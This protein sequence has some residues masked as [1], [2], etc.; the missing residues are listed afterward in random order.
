[1]EQSLLDKH[2]GFSTIHQVVEG[3]YDG[4]LEN[5]ILAP[6][7]DDTNTNRSSDAVLCCRNGWSYFI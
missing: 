2:G 1:M 3:F 7:F 6:Y 4:V 5:E